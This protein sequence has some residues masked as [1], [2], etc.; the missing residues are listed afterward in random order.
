MQ[1]LMMNYRYQ[2]GEYCGEPHASI[3]GLHQH[4]LE[5]HPAQVLNNHNRPI[6]INKISLMRSGATR[7]GVDC[8]REARAADGEVATAEEK[9]G[10]EGEEGD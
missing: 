5:D 1:K 9:G 10:K 2:S 3:V 4:L 6:I 8:P 7:K